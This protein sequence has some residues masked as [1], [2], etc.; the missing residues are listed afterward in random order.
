MQVAACAVCG[1]KRLEKYT[2][3]PQAAGMLHFAQVRCDTCGLLISQPQ[4]SP[5]EIERYYRETYYALHWPDAAKLAAENETIYGRHEWPLMQRLWARWPPPKGR[6]IVEIGCGYGAL[7]PLAVRDGYSVAGCD[8]SADAVAFCR[9]RGFNVV[10]GSV[11]GSPFQE[12][13]DTVIA[14]HVIEHVPDPRT[15][16]RGLV[17]AAES[18]GR[19]VIV[20]EDAWNS[21]YGWERCLARIRGRVPRFRTSTDHTFV[22]SGA[23]LD[24]LLRDAG[25]DEV[26]TTSFSYAP[27]PESLHWKI[28]K[29]TFRAL[30]RILGRGDFLMAVGRVRAD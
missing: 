9:S 14:Q 25:C 10:Q 19:V 11:P 22:F 15:F 13:F 26:A 2:S 5:T 21:Q 28:Y 18:G 3:D 23:H 30:D 17:E 27:P 4:A 29:G 7:L 24:R 16:V 6:S 20:T 12:R 8:P 1:G